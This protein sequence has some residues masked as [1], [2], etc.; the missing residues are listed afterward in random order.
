MTKQ[1][2]DRLV[3]FSGIVVFAGIL[4]LATQADVQRW[5]ISGT[6]VG[7]RLRT[8]ES[9]VLPATAEHP[10]APAASDSGPTAP[11]CDATTSDL[12]H[13]ASAWMTC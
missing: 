13:S 7:E 12:V 4:L 1:W 10:A 5:T 6:S 8:L 11:D 2:L 3:Q 9:C